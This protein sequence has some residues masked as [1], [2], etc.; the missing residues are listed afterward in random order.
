MIRVLFI[1]LV[2]IGLAFACGCGSPPPKR[3]P[4][5]EMRRLEAERAE[6]EKLE[7]ERLAKEAEE[8]EPNTIYGK[9]LKKAKDLKKKTDAYNSRLEELAKPGQR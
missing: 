4:A 8:K 7:Q 1:C 3:K 6:A 5:A 9:A 2:G